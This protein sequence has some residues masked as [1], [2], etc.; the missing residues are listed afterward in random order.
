MMDEH[1]FQKPFKTSTNKKPTSSHS[2]HSTNKNSNSKSL[3]NSNRSNSNSNLIPNAGQRSKSNLTTKNNEI[4]DGLKKLNSNINLERNGSMPNLNTIG[5]RMRV[6]KI[7][8]LRFEYDKYLSSLEAKYTFQ[9]TEKKI[10][11]N[12]NEQKNIFREEFNLL[13]EQLVTLTEKIKLI[14][15]LKIEKENLDKKCEVLEML[16]KNTAFNDTDEEIMSLFTSV[17]SKVIVNNFKQMDE[18]DLN[19]VKV[20]MEEIIEP[21]KLIDYENKTKTRII[22]KDLLINMTMLTKELDNYKLK[23]EELFVKQE[24]LQNYN[25]SMQILKDQF[26]ENSDTTLP[27]TMNNLIENIKKVLNEEK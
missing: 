26:G 7:T 14:S 9:V 16:N 2:I 23:C 27:P 4:S 24:N 3:T 22:L 8:K 15:K 13:K 21:L 10:T 11:A 6:D 19:T 1:T 20:L 12:I 18:T 5:S 17:A 25:T